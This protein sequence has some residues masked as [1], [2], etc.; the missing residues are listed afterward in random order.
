MDNQSSVAAEQPQQDAA[1]LINLTTLI[2]ALQ[3]LSF[4]VG[5]T[6]IAAVFINYVKADEV[7]GTWL[8]SHFR[9]Q[10]K[11]FWYSILWGVIGIITTFFIIGFFILF[12]DAVWM[13]YRIVKGWLNLSDK[14]PMYI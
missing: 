10:K 14:R 13:I 9:W 2:Y 7:R 12:A 6:L 3:A 5:I 4:L 1:S 11:T 8:E